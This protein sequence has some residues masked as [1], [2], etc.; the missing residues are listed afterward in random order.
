MA[1]STQTFFCPGLASFWRARNSGATTFSGSSSTVASW[2]EAAGGGAGRSQARRVFQEKTMRPCLRASSTLSTGS[3][4][5]ASA[6]FSNRS[7]R[8]MAS[9][10]ASAR[11]DTLTDREPL[12]SGAAAAGAG[13]GS[14]ARGDGGSRIGRA[15]GR[16]E[17]GMGGGA[18]GGAGGGAKVIWARAGGMIGSGAGSAAGRAGGRTTGG[19][20]AAGAAAAGAAAGGLAGPIT[21]VRLWLR[22]SKGLRTSSGTWTCDCTRRQAIRAGLSRDRISPRGSGTIT[23]SRS[24]SM[25][26][27]PG[28]AWRSSPKEICTTPRESWERIFSSGIIMVTMLTSTLMTRACS[29]RGRPAKMGFKGSSIPRPF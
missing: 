2:M 12:S 1:L 16:A 11:E 29:S 6:R 9:G 24:F 3:A 23:R 25:V 10:Q 5:R 27:R 8:R 14:G 13:A 21:R 17:K 4:T 20:A 15:K 19:G 7:S 26:K 18:A 28:A 22:S